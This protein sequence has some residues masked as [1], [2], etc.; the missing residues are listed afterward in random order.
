MRIEGIY[1]I[2]KIVNPIGEIYIGQSLD[3][4]GRFATYKRHPPKGQHLLYKSIK[5][6][7][8]DNHEKFLIEYCPK[9]LAN[10]RETFHIEKEK[11]YFFENPKGLNL[12]KGGNWTKPDTFYKSIVQYDLEG[13]FI[14]KWDG[15]ILASAALNCSAAN[16]GRCLKGR[17][18]SLLGFQWKYYT[19]NYPLNI[20]KVI[21]QEKWLEN[22]KLQITNLK[23]L[24]VIKYEN[25]KDLN[26]KTKLSRD[27][28]YGALTLRNGLMPQKK[29]QIEIIKD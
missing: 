1:A 28:I 9:E 15:I 12:T 23:T 6:Y 21:K 29:L 18:R 11:S 24:E 17:R 20:G 25:F 14:K 22:S 19:E 5:R 2:Y 4:E 7:G 3:W 13:N 10:D 26:S 16:I 27:S 8:W